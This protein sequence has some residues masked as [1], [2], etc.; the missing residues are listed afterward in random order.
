MTVS[1]HLHRPEYFFPGTGAL[2]DVG[3][4]AGRNYSVNVPLLEGV[5][6][7]Q[8][9]GLFKP[10]MR[11]VMDVFAPQAIVLQCG[12]G[13]GRIPFVAFVCKHLCCVAGTLLII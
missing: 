10:I 5:D 13:L 4:Y 2:H 1:F 12:E 6:D 8:Y 11:K 3:E 9:M 7:D